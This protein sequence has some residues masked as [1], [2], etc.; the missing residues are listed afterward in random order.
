M[1]LNLDTYEQLKQGEY[2]APSVY[3]AAMKNRLANFDAAAVRERLEKVLQREDVSGIVAVEAVEDGYIQVVLGSEDAEDEDHNAFFIF[4]LRVHDSVDPEDWSYEAAEYRNRNLLEDERMEMQQT[5][6]LL[7]CMTYL[8]P[9]WPQAHWMLQFAVTDAVA[10]DCYALQDMVSGQF[11]SGSWLADL[12][13]TYTPPSLEMGYVIH[14]VTPED[15]HGDDYWMHTHGLLKFGLPELEIL[16]AQRAQLEQ[17]QGLFNSVSQILLDDPA[18]WHEDA[19][20]LCAQTQHGNIAVRLMP[21]QTALRSDLLA[22][23]KK[24]FFRQK[25]Q[26]FNGDLGEREADDIHTEPALV[27]FADINGRPAHLADLGAA[28]AE[29][30]HVMLMLPNSETARMYYLAKEKLPL[31]AACLQ[32]HPPQEEVWTYLMKIRCESPSTE[33]AEHM[34]FAVQSLTD[35]EVTAELINEPFQI[36]EMQCGQ[37]YTLPLDEASDWCIYAAPLQA[38]I[39]PDNVFHLRRY[40]RAS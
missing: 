17:Y 33:A 28:V 26:R 36:P 37:T 22:P 14:V 6:Q 3:L 13:E 25:I 8:D 18:L 11:F 5:P 27:M 29:D 19:P 40:L 2:Q 7:E 20:L 31:F 24:G 12:A 21:W 9:D 23:V 38:R 10:G 32:S 35:T 39:T 1:D 34:W 15:A 16:R 4:R 30:T